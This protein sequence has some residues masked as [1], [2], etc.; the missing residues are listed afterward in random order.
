MFGTRIVFT[1]MQI[2]PKEIKIQSKWPKPFPMTVSK[3]ESLLDVTLTSSLSSSRNKICF[4]NKNVIMYMC[5]FI[6]SFSICFKLVPFV[7][8]NYSFSIEIFNKLRWAPKKNC[9]RFA[10]VVLFHSLVIFSIPCCAVCIQPSNQSTVFFF[11]GNILY[12][13]LCIAL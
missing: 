12:T 4:E 11:D 7:H 2:L 13:C 9:I 5:W 10:I 1:K 3:I 8:K 6:F